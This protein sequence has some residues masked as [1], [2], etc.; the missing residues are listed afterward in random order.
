MQLLKISKTEEYTHTHTYMKY[1]RHYYLSIVCE[2][3]RSSVGIYHHSL[4]L[5]YHRAYAFILM[6][7]NKGHKEV[8]LDKN[9]Q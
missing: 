6:T 4:W 3:T 1:N 9:E 2:T 8:V 5:S 7:K